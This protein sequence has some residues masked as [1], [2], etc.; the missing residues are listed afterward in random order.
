MQYDLTQAPTAL[1]GSIFK[2]KDS[3]NPFTLGAIFVAALLTPG[4]ADRVLSGEQKQARYNLAARLYQQPTAELGAEEV[5]VLKEVVGRVFPTGLAGPV[6]NM[7]D[8]NSVPVITPTV[9]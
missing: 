3:G 6:F 4:D 5:T 8:A 2:D 7:I 9:E 1:D